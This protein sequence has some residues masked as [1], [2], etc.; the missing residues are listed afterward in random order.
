MPMS[1]NM[2]RPEYSLWGALNDPAAALF[3]GHQSAVSSRAD[4]RRRVLRLPRAPHGP[5]QGNH[6]ARSVRRPDRRLGFP[7]VS[8]AAATGVLR[9]NPRLRRARGGDDG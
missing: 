9:P 4:A 1:K 7:L 2:R 6:F 5:D 3:A 8:D